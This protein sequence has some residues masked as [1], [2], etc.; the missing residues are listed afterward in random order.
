MPEAGNVVAVYG[1]TGHTG[2]FVVQE[3]LQRGYS[4]RLVARNGEKLAALAGGCRGQVSWQLGSLDEPASLNRAFVGAAAVVNCAGPFLDTAAT[5][6]AAALQNDAH[7]VDVAA[8]Q[9]AVLD[10]RERFA[11]AART[12]QRIVLPAMAFYGGLADL[13]ATA[14]AD[15][16][17]SV[18]D[19]E[20]AIALDRWWPTPG[21]RR[22]GERNT[23]PRL[24]V[25]NGELVPLADTRVRRWRFPAPFGEQD[26]R[27]VP[28][29]EIVTLAQHFTARRISTYLNL[30]PLRDLHDRHTPPPSAA[31]DSGRSLQT[32]LM[33]VRVR[34]G[35]TERRAIARGRDIYA[36]TAPLVAEAVERILD[37][38]VQHT[39]VT[40][41]GALFDARDFLTALAPVPLAVEF[42][43]PDRNEESAAT[44]PGGRQ[45]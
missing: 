13:L 35:A 39:G 41:A 33:E 32:F 25:A 16:R 43:S 36:I 44:E 20:V 21:T 34:S 18:D 22:T 23:G 26:V 38:R 45:C 17:Q 28:L 1:A 40:T 31:D 37:G 29:S 30:A 7:Y 10:V 11:D 8:E 42:H 4:L 24:V 6:V 2:R 12:S 14:V 3:L 27:P 19:I 15:E 5:V 9:R